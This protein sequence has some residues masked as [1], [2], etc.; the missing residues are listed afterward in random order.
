MRPVVITNRHSGL[1]LDR[2]AVTRMIHALDDNSAR[3]RV[4]KSDFLGGE[5]SVVFL[6]DLALARLH[7]QFLADPSVTDVITFEGEPTFGNAGEVCVSADAAARQVG[8]TSGKAGEANYSRELAL[9]IV[10]GWLHLAGYDDLTPEKKR[11]MR[12]AESRAMSVLRQMKCLPAFRL[13]A[14]K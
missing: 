8:R 11:A 14:R 4:L 7:G 3:I 1:R 10:H 5:L 13:V 2:R 9:Y 12:R 6:T